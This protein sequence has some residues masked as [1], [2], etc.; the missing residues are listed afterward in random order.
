M[1][2]SAL[3]ALAP[4]APQQDAG[5][6]PGLAAGRAPAV[7]IAWNRLYDVEELYGHFE[8]LRAHWPELVSVEVIGH[9]VEG[10]EL[11]IYTLNDPASGAIGSKPAMWIDGNV[12][13]NEVQGGEAVLYAA[14]YLL[15]NRGHNARVDAILENSTFYLLPMV[16]PDGRASWFAD[17]HNAHSS[18]SGRRPTDDDGDGRYDED[19]PDDLDGDGN[20]VQMRKHT[21]GEG[22]HRLD[23]DDPRVL[24]RVPDTTG[25]GRGDWTM[26]GSEGVDNDGDGRVNEDSVGGYDMN[27]AWPSLWQ[28]EHVQ[29]G[30][31][32]YP[33]Y[34][35][36]TRSIARFVLEHPEIAGVQSFHNAGGMI[37]RGPGAE[38][39]GEYPRAD[40]R[41]YDELGAD[42][43]RMLPFYRY[44]IIW[45]DLYSVFG[46]FVTWTYEALGVISF[47]NELWNDEQLGLGPPAGARRDPHFLDDALLLGAGFVAWHEVEHP[48]YGTVEVGGFKKDVGRVPPT[49]LIEEMLHRN[50]L[51]AIR[52]AEA[53][54][55][56]VLEAP[57]VTDL[58][59]G[60]WAVDAVVRNEHLIPTRSARAAEVKAGRADRLRLEGE[61]LEVLAGGWRE[62]RW[63]PERIELAEREPQALPLE[64]GVPGRGERRARWLVRGSGSF[65]VLFEAEKARDVAAEGRL[66]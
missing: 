17:A 16:N 49:F 61:G 24:V 48:L 32:A 39:F 4:L 30:A 19:G 14:W 51:F 29:G 25:G 28:P 55:R 9:S 26:L 38:V 46:G 53:M 64:A 22:T 56:V 43:E 57:V 60:L 65:R 3:L 15:E 40:L 36:E 33:L 58:G 62:D 11:R 21:P 45:R 42:G 7:E 37:L 8:R 50:A 10:R 23:P 31:G 41:A 18:R 52:H 12:H 66:P 35:P 1:I 2:L 6:F 34:W 5:G 54:P 63:R 59:G 44:M 47:T 13:G 20:I 27:R